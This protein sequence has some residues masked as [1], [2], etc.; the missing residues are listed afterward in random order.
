MNS[1]RRNSSRPCARRA[2]EPEDGDDPLVLDLERR[3]GLEVDLVQDDDLRQLV[4]AG[5][6]GGELG[7]DRPPLLLGRLRRVDH[8]HERPRALEVR[9]ELVAEPDALARALDQ[10][11]D[12]GDDELAPVGRLDRAEHRLRAS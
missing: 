6:V 10:P 5:A 9:E 2:R 1:R 4:E 11:G 7:V 8:V 3:L 12:V